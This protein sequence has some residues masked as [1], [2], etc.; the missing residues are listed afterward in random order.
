MAK[1]TTPAPVSA[2]YGFGGRYVIDPVTGIRTKAAEAAVRYAPCSGSLTAPEP[3]TVPA[4][5][6]LDETGNP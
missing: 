6:T 1:T 5:V 4:T 2:P 3:E